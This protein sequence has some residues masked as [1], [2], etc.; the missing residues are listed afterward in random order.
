MRL[1]QTIHPRI[2]YLDSVRGLAA[3]CTLI[4][5]WLFTFEDGRALSMQTAHFLNLFINGSD[6]VSLFFVLSGLVLSY[7]YF[8]TE[9][10]NLNYKT[11]R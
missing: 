2:E 4:G 9:D 8:K 6:A 7:K 5:H 10:L 3:L 11:S 1:E